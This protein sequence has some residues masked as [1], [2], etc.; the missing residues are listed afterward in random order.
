MENQHRAT[1]RAV[2]HRD[3]SLSRTSDPRYTLAKIWTKLLSATAAAMP[4][5]QFANMPLVLGVS[6]GADSV[7]M[8]RLVA[9]LWT[10]AAETDPR[11]LV[12]A[13]YNHAVR[14]AAADGDEA[15]TA[16]LAKSLSLEFRSEKAEYHVDS[17]ARSHGEAAFRDA[18]YR[19][20]E[21]VLS[22]T[23]ARAAFVAHTADDNIET[24]LHQLFRGTGPTGLA[25]MKPQR[26]LGPE[27]VLYRPLLAMRRADLRAGLVEIDQDWREDASNNDVQYQR[28][29]LRGELM[30]LIRTRYPQADAAIL[31]TIETQADGVTA[32]N[33]A[34]KFWIDTNVHFGANQV[35]IQRGEITS[36][37]FA[38][39]LNRVWDKQGWP[40]GDLSA[41]H[42]RNLHAT[43]TK[44]T[45]QAFMLPGELRCASEP[46]LVIVQCLALPSGTNA[47]PQI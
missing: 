36:A 11:Q 33:H 15:F 19:F 7:A 4:T 40:R 44:Q 30:P 24:V 38:A 42:L 29:W 27:C 13:H 25:G 39:A 8:L 2:D 46:A 47:I 37:I 1:N 12:V 6:G 22:A 21:S 31:R 18:R 41:T 10:Q 35:T 32:I 16:N 28:N 5:A 17:P 43:V 45:D 34:A 9:E 3:T 23:G 14:G 26:T 20:F